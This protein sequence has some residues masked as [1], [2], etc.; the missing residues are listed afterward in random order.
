MTLMSN[1]ISWLIETI[2]FPFYFFILRWEDSDVGTFSTSKS[3]IS[4]IIMFVRDNVLSSGNIIE[5]TTD[6]LP[7]FPYFQGDGSSVPI[8]LKPW[9][10]AAIG[11]K[12]LFCSQTL[13][14]LLQND[15]FNIWFDMSQMPRY[16]ITTKPY[17]HQTVHVMTFNSHVQ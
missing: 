16:W 9:Q 6:N 15:R 12:I 14:N 17:F 5:L 3:G 8:S 13:S 10:S 1:C 4:P 2:T 11:F 7:I